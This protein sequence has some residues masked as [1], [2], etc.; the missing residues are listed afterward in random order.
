LPLLLAGIALRLYG[1]TP[2]PKDLTQI[3]LED[4][5]NVQVTSVSKKEQPLSKTGAAVFVISQE[6]IRRSGAHNPPDIPRMGPG[7]TVEQVN[8][9][10]RS[11]GIR[12]F[13]DLDQNKVLV[14]IDGRSIYRITSSTVN[15]EELDVPLEDIE[16]IEIGGEA[17]NA[18]ARWRVTAGYSRLHVATSLDPSSHDESLAPLG[19]ATPR[20]RFDL[21]AFAKLSRRLEWD[22]SAA[23]TG[24]VRG[25]QVRAY[26]RVDTRLGW[27]WNEKAEL[28]VTG[29][30]LLSPRHAESVD[31][32]G[33][34]HTLV[35]RSMAV[36]LAWRF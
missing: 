32:D 12:G 1:A 26:A 14:M 25:G 34:L 7:V 15:W 24:P 19:G 31:E 5:M 36:R 4:P 20:N 10:T 16:R 35:E 29:Q 22:A 3:S 18:T 13:N 21:R 11:I 17:W 27:H 6:D 28:S 23:Y 2:N 8:A 33:T 30:N 9:N